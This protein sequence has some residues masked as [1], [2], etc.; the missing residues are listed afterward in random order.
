MSD[1][2]VPN[3]IQLLKIELHKLNEKIDALTN[4]LNVHIV[5]IENVFDYVK[6]PLF[7]VV[8]KI[9]NIFLLNDK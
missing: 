1:E 7:F 3:D 2:H 5:F 4:V 6:K 9:N 8:D